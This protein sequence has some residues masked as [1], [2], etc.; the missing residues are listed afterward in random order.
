MLWFPLV[1]CI[2]LS[3]EQPRRLSCS[4][5]FYHTRNTLSLHVCFTISAIFSTYFYTAHDD[6]GITIPYRNLPTSLEFPHFSGWK[7]VPHVFPSLAKR[8]PSADG[9]CFVCEWWVLFYVTIRIWVEMPRHSKNIY[10]C[11]QCG[12]AY[13]DT[14]AKSKHPALRSHPLF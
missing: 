9:G 13:T 3:E 7:S 5:T 1:S 8:V 14:H 2:L 12:F 11:F 4:K 10:S 6:F